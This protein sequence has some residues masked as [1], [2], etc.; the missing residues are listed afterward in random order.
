AGARRDGARESALLVAEELALEHALGEGLR[1]HGDER[2]ADALAPVMEQAGDQLLPRPALALD[3]HRG[4][5]RRP[6]ADQRPEP[7][8]PR[9]SRAV[10][11]AAPLAHVSHSWPARRSAAAITSAMRASSSTMRTRAVMPRPGGRA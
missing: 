4:P 5:A 1:I 9:A 3:Q 6:A 7:P 8:A 10:S 11:A 2:A